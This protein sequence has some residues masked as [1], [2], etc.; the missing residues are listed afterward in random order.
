MKKAKWLSLIAIIF[1][2]T[3]VLSTTASASHL[4][5]KKF[6]I[7]QAGPTPN[8]STDAATLETR[9]AGQVRIA[10][11][12]VSGSTTLGWRDLKFEIWGRSPNGTL[13]KLGETIK[14]P[15]GRDTQTVTLLDSPPEQ[16]MIRTLGGVTH[17]SIQGEVVVWGKPGASA[18]PEVK[19]KNLDDI[20]DILVDATFKYEW[21]PLEGPTAGTLTLLGGRRIVHIER[22]SSGKLSALVEIPIETP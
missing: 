22:T 6:I 9:G 8:P 10:V 4:D 19:V 11:R 17:S 14:M 12:Y 1:F 7:P 20:W 3:I 18:N 5:S 16:I 15:D 2:T 13:F 21:V